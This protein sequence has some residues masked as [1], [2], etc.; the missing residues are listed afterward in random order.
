MGNFEAALYQPALEQILK[1][2]SPKIA[3][4]RK[5]INRWAAS[6][7]FHFALIQWLEYFFFAC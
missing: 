7:Y 3:N 5:I 6:V 1:Q 2:K 4:V